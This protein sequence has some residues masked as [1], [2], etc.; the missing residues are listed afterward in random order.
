MKVI[1]IHV[2]CPVKSAPSMDDYVRT[3]DEFGV[4]AAL[5]HA[6]ELKFAQP[7]RGNDDVRRV[8][9]RHPGRLYG[10]GYV[11]LRDPVRKSIKAVERFAR[12]GFK[13]VKMF[14]NI[15]FDPSDER[16][17]PFWAAVEANG[18]HCLSHC[19]W[20]GFTRAN[21]WVSSVTATPSHFE[22]PARRHPGINFI[23]G[24]FGGAPYYIE[25]IVVT[26]RLTNFFGDV[27]PGW[28][29]WVFENKMPGLRSLRFKQVLYGT[30]SMGKRYG[31]DIR[32]WTK[33][34]RELGCTKE[35]LQNFFY[36]NGA[37]ILGLPE[38]PREAQ[39][40]RADRRKP[41]EMTPKKR[42]K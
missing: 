32:W 3:M 34:L 22:A 42:R 30:D 25:T 29:R 18:L 28:G 10:S 21:D 12:W 6:V 35:D 19:G 14:P 17:E 5:V 38:I 13:S 36:N 20:L 11:D 8:V 4:E 26:S 39:G 16:H 23:M 9:E 40:A 7:V 2:H 1:D 37:R 33:T 27:T 31:E 15:G 24:H 41:D